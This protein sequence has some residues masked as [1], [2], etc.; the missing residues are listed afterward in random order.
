MQSRP[1]EGGIGQLLACACA[2]VDTKNR[3][4]LGRIVGAMV[5]GVDT[6]ARTLVPTSVGTEHYSLVVDIVGGFVEESAGAEPSLSYKITTRLLETLHARPEPM[7]LRH[8]AIW[9]ANTNISAEGIATPIIT[10]CCFDIKDC[11][12]KAAY[13]RTLDAE[14]GVQWRSLRHF[15]TRAG[16]YKL[17]FDSSLQ[18]LRVPA[19]MYDEIDSAALE[20]LLRLDDASLLERT[21]TSPLVEGPDFV[22]TV[23][24]N[25]TYLKRF[26]VSSDSSP[27]QF[28]RCRDCYGWH[29]P[30]LR[31]LSIGPSTTAL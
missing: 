14:P 20:W 7:I 24:K 16:G 5:E 13:T 9:T 12:L 17:I 25:F 1:K 8:S 3:A 11:S 31:E 21:S 28:D 22:E 30:D 29:V 10:G 4:Q 19:V 6:T 26:P 18:S 27:K 2:H 15:D 23:R